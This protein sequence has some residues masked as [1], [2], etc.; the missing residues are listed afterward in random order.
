[1]I[2]L[3]VFALL[4]KKN[5]QKKELKEETV[6]CEEKL[7]SKPQ[8]RADEKGK[9]VASDAM[10]T[11]KIASQQAGRQLHGPLSRGLKGPL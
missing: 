7:H 8:Q 6:Q 2:L 1:M 11:K 4:K 5:K 9:T 10:C 3:A